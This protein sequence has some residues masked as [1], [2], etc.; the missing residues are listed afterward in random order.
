MLKLISLFFGL[1]AAYCFWGVYEYLSLSA[2]LSGCLSAAAAIGLWREKRWAQYV[3][4]FISA[5]I[6]L[7]FGWYMWGLVG[8]G[9]PYQDTVRSV[10]SLIPGTLILMFG[11]GA[12]AHVF[13]VFRL[14]K[15][16]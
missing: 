14:K 13:R 11:I 5:S 10:I 3:V 15:R 4:Y 6:G 8:S 2:L 7:Y 1:H 16:D 12:S 9:W